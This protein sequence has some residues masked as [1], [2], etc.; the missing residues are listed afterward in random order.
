MNFQTPLT[1][2]EVENQ[3]LHEYL[4]NILTPE[5]KIESVPLPLKELMHLAKLI[6][7]AKRKAKKRMLRQA[8]ETCD[9]E[10]FEQIAKEF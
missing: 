4:I 6:K 5:G 8:K 2:I 1:T 10:L 3:Q 7:K 9:Y